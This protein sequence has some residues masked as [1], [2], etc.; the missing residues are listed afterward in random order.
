MKNIEYKLKSG[1]I[2]S[3]TQEEFYEILKERCKLFDRQVL[4]TI[5]MEEFAELIEVITE[6]EIKGRIDFVHLKEE[7]VDCYI[8]LMTLGVLFD[9]DYRSD[10]NAK[11]SKYRSSNLLNNCIQNLSVGI[12]TISKCIREKDNA[13]M[14][15]V[16]LINLIT[17]SLINIQSFY[18]ITHDT[19]EDIFQL[20]FKRLE[21]RN[22]K[23]TVK[24][25][26]QDSKQDLNTVDDAKTA[27]A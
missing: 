17:E 10:M 21:E 4:L 20:K 15:I 14:K 22:I 9:T 12:I 5:C 19:L 18:H 6:N 3:Y 26:I 24:E 13:E 23:K 1:D 27:N 8:C 16:S 2:P 11:Y 7:I 25:T